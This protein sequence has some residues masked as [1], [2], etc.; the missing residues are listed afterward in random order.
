MSH[1]VVDKVLP[2]HCRLLGRLILAADE[3]ERVFGLPELAVP[4]PELA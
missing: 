2:L 1:D 4:A 3:V